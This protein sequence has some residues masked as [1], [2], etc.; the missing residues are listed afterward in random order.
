MT[1]RISVPHIKVTDNTVV[2]K[3][4]RSELILD[5]E[6]LKKRK[7][8]DPSLDQSKLEV[9]VATKKNDILKLFEDLPF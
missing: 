6:E 8:N 7:G 4:P 2:C 5:F 3:I 1:R 9:F